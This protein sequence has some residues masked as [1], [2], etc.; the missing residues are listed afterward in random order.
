ME[1]TCCLREAQVKSA[2]GPCPGFHSIR[3]LGVFYSSRDGMP[4]PGGEGVVLASNGLLGI[5]I[6]GL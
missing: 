2:F 1:L 5:R 6:W 3:Q 4:F